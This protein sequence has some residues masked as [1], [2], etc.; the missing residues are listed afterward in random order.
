MCC[1]L[2]SLSQAT[3]SFSKWNLTV[4]HSW[5]ARRRNGQFLNEVMSALV[6]RQAS[7]WMQ[8]VLVVTGMPLPD[9]EHLSSVALFSYLLQPHASDAPPPT[10]PGTCWHKL[11]PT[12]FNTLT[13][14]VLSLNT[15]WGL[16]EPLSALE[17]Y[18]SNFWQ[19]EWVINPLPC[20][21]PSM[22]SSCVWSHIAGDILGLRLC[23]LALDLAL[24]F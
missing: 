15:L 16:M 3:L 8:R 1:C 21:P 19:K 10:H 7:A 23:V 20:H 18:L 17:E 11:N 9:E 24:I 12:Q 14:C 6:Q 22:E 4:R 5:Y 2:L 13:V